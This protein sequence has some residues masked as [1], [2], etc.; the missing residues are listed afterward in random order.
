MGQNDKF[1]LNAILSERQTELAPDLSESEFFETFVTE[2]ILRNY[3]LSNEEIDAGIIGGGNDGGIDAIYVFI[4]DRLLVPDFDFEHVGSEPV[5]KLVIIQAKRS[6][7]F[8]SEAIN[9]LIES[10]HDLLNMETPLKNFSTKYNAQ[11]ISTIDDYRLAITEL[12]GKFPTLEFQ[13]FYV[14]KGDSTKVHPNVR[15]RIEALRDEIS[16]YF[17]E[18]NFD[19]HF[20]GARDLITLT[21]QQSIDTLELRVQ[22]YLTIGDEGIVCL[23]TLADYYRFLI[24]PSGERRQVIFDSNVRDYEGSVE[25]NKGIRKTLA[26]T[27]GPANF[28]WLNNGVTIVATKAPLMGKS[29]HLGNPKVV[30]GLQTSQEIYEFFK[31]KEKVDDNRLLL[32]RVIVTDDDDIRNQIIKATNSQTRIPPYSLR[33]TE[34]IHQDI[35]VF[36]KQNGLYY[37]RQKNYYK[38]MGVPRKKIVTIPYLAQSVA[39]I[40]LQEPNNARGRPTN[41][42]KDDEKYSQIFSEEYD[43]RVYLKCVQLMKL[44]DGFLRHNAPD[45]AKNERTNLRFHLATFVA[46]VAMGEVNVT[47]KNF[48]QKVIIDDID[49]SFLNSCLNHVWH[50]FETL[51]QKHGLEGSRIAKNREFDEAVIRRAR[52]IVEKQIPLDLEIQSA[53]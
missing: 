27:K 23:V 12:A 38:N 53:T 41:L 7:G 50:V 22:E 42:I 40:I 26:D 5:I 44:I 17:S 37:D 3:G 25:V 2:E 6:S 9:K 15:Q 14:T 52:Q 32:V 4:N 48:V 28:W 19:F 24:D 16:R 34:Q 8:S 33:A 35:E 13:Y 20:L 29:L 49:E 39:A 11:L 46:I 47:P 31:K 10:A 21:R 45:Y 36:F 1:L 51:K 43:I 18:F 30:N